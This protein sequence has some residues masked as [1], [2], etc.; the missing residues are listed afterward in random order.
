M[1]KH[2]RMPVKRKCISC[3]VNAYYSQSFR[4]GPAKLVQVRGGSWGTT[5][6]VRSAR[7]IWALAWTRGEESPSLRVSPLRPPDHEPSHVTPPISYRKA[8]Y[9]RTMQRIGANGPQ[10]R[11]HILSLATVARAPQRRPL[12]PTEHRGQQRTCLA[13]AD[14]WRGAETA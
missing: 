2:T 8:K 11:C 7:R 9:R 6:G 1:G 5:F 4:R 14:P 12:A 3:W 10:C 13:E